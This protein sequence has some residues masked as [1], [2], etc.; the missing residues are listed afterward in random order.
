MR[1][2]YAIDS[3]LDVALTD[4]YTKFYH[5]ST[6]HASPYPT[7]V[8]QLQVLGCWSCILLLLVDRCVHH[9]V[10]WLGRQSWAMRHYMHPDTDEHFLRDFRDSRH[11]VFDFRTHTYAC[12]AGSRTSVACFML[13][14]VCSR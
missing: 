10:S 8:H 5:A 6:L 11:R 3:R 14:C 9:A 4:I 2:Q 7:V 1:L 12:C 13:V